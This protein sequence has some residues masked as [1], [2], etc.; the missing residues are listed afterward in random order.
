MKKANKLTQPW[1]IV[2]GA[3][4]GIGSELLR[5]L[6]NTYRV[7]A[8]SR[9]P[10]TT[11]CDK[12]IDL[13]L[14]DDTHNGWLEL[15]AAVRGDQIYAVAHLA[16]ALG[17]RI[18]LVNQDIESWKDVFQVTVD[19]SL[20]LTQICWSGLTQ[21]DNSRCIFTTSGA[22]RTLAP[23]MG[24]Y[25]IAKAALERFAQILAIESGEKGP[26]VV[27]IN[28]GPTTTAMRALVA[29]DED[30]STIASPQ[31]IAKVFLKYLFSQHLEQG[32][33]IEAQT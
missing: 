15:E 22:A 25:G 11:P 32:I 31:V 6:P 3:S 14:A 2:S 29:P 13:D 26:K 4:G 1:I 12:W 24:A 27:T 18:P 5:L 16:A 17:Q 9:T 10:I 20:K 28:P 19:S 8:L 7:I 21:V 30:P 23:H 33:R